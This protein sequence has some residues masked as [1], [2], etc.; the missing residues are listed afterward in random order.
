[1]C[2][3]LQAHIASRGR[4]H[5]QHDYRERDPAL[6]EKSVEDDLREDEGR[7]SSSP[8]TRGTYARVEY[9]AGACPLTVF[10]QRTRTMPSPAAVTCANHEACGNEIAFEDV[11][12]CERHKGRSSTD[13]YAVMAGRWTPERVGKH[14]YMRSC[15][16]PKRVTEL[17]L[18]SRRTIC[19]RHHRQ[20]S[21]L[22]RP[23][24]ASQEDHESQHTPSEA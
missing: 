16:Q 23:V 11:R 19:T 24:Q 20:N 14:V 3:S 15:L 1:M 21:V 2:I 10:V 8:R 7:Q 4:M 6:S 18:S 22:R 17:A 12:G 13:P 5:D 9:M